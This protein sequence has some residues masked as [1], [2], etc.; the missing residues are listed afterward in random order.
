MTVANDVPYTVAYLANSLGLPGI[1]LETAELGSNKLKMK[2]AFIKV[3]AMVPKF[4][5]V[6]EAKDLKPILKEWNNNLIIKPTDN[7]GARG[8]LLV[9]ETTNLNWAFDHARKHSDIGE[10]IV[11]EFI[12]GA[13]L[14]TEGFVVNGICYTVAFSD[15]NYEKIEE[16]RPYIIE[17]GGTMPANLDDAVKSKVKHQ[18]QLAANALG[19]KNGPIKGDIVIDENFNVYII[20]IATRLSGG[21]FCTDQIPISTDVDLVD[22]TMKQA[23]GMDIEAADLTPVHKCYIAI[24]YWFPQKGS[25]VDIPD[26]IKIQKEPDVVKAEIHHKVGSIFGKVEKHPDRLGFVIVTDMNSYD[27]AARK[28]N[29]IISKYDK[30]FVFK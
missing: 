1:S 21:Y 23:L 17:N 29:T 20:E 18:L 4:K 13:Q 16:Y 8:V 27:L 10:V 2:E 7:R 12:Q 30:E 3:G 5:L 11:E 14:S 6:A 22:V 28:A 25:L 15:R 24:R 9:D 19:L 26:I